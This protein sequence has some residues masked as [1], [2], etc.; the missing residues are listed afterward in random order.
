M[1]QQPLLFPPGGP[2]NKPPPVKAKR[3]APG[4][5]LL[6]SPKFSPR[7]HRILRNPHAPLVRV[8]MPTRRLGLTQYSEWKVYEV[9]NG[10]GYMGTLNRTWIKPHEQNGIVITNHRLPTAEYMQRHPTV[11]PNDVYVEVRPAPIPQAVTL[12]GSQF[13]QNYPASLRDL[14]IDG[15]ERHG[16]LAMT[17]GLMS[18]G[19]T[20][21]L[22]VVDQ[23]TG[24]MIGMLPPDENSLWLDWLK[25]DHRFALWIN[26][27]WHIVETST[28]AITVKLHP[29]WSTTSS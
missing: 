25:K 10:I 6:G 24:L 16:R 27:N 29:Y 13:N 26:V 1:A 28:P 21:V 2:A 8:L 7:Q 12:I 19:K 9:N 23:H 15:D 14:I 11:G 17:T 20:E 5:G 22:Q 3:K 4:Y 18:D